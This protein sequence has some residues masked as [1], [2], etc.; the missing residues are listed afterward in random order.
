METAYHFSSLF[1]SLTKGKLKSSQCKVSLFEET[2]ER[3]KNAWLIGSFV[4][5]FF[6]ICTHNFSNAEPK[7][8]QHHFKRSFSGF[9]AMLTEEEA[10]RMASM[11]KNCFVFYPLSKLICLLF[12]DSHIH[13]PR[14]LS[15]QDM[16]EL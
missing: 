2:R 10:D 16:I 1:S 14:I 8:V 3:T 7:L 11:H 5:T 12:L 9:V 4:L 6:L 15:M 13:Q